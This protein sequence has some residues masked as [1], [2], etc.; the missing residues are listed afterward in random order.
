MKYYS[1]SQNNSG[2]SFTIDKE[3]GLTVE[4]V[5][6]ANSPEEANDR[7]EEIGGYFD[8]VDD[9]RDCDCC[10]DR[11]YRTEEWKASDTIPEVKNKSYKWAN[12]GEEICVHYADGT[13]K[14]YG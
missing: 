4:V 6:E 3:R 5:V 9:D 14:W 10:G 7:F 8:G 12:E 1:F 11:W 2:G 13:R